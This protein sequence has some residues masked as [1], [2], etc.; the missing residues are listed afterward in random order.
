[1]IALQTLEEEELEAGGNHRRSG[2]RVL[3]QHRQKPEGVRISRGDKLDEAA[4][5]QPTEMR[6]AC[7]VRKSQEPW[8]VTRR[9]YMF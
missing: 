3:G 8:A 2:P 9:R 4:R 1:M 6:M 7:R 5:D